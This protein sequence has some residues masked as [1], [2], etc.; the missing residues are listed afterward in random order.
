[1]THIRILFTAAVLS[2]AFTLQAAAD[3]THHPKTQAQSAAAI[4]LAQGEVRK[5]DKEAG[6]VTIKHGPL[7]SLDMPAMTMVFR[8]KDPAMLDQIKA[9]D[10]INFAA[11]KVDGAYTVMRIETAK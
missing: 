5:V 9:G 1:M 6:K 10:K 8:V 11:D 4:G 3:D 2:S 7:T